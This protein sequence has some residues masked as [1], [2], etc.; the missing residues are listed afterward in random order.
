M[1][2]LRKI[3][4]EVPEETAERLEASAQ[5]RGMSMA[6]FLTDIAGANDPWPPHL[7]KMRE[8]GRGPWSP[9]A[10]A[11]DAADWEEYQ[12]TGVGVPWDEVKAWMESWGT[13]NELPPPKP[14]KL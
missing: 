12:R 7:E 4:V 6:E 2:K 10:L 14:R 1:A 8:E 13:A 3:E 11:E 5:E 9:E